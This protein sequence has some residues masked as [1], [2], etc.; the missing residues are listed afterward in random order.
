LRQVIDAHVAR[1]G[2]G[3]QLSNLDSAFAYNMAPENLSRCP[4]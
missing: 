4:L 1:H 2:Y 3:G